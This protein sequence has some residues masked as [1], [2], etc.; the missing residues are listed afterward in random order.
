MLERFLGQTWVMVVAFIAGPAI[1]YLMHRRRTRLAEE[2]SRP[3]GTAAG[4]PAAL[5]KAAPSAAAVPAPDKAGVRK[6][7]WPGFRG[8]KWGQPPVEGMTLVHEEGETRF[9]VR[10]SDELRIG[11]VQIGSATYSF[12]IGRLEAVV[13]DLPLAGFELLTR[14]LTS[15]WGTPKSA[16]DRGKHVW[17]DPGTGPDDSQAVLEKRTESRTARLVLSSRAALAERSQGR[18]G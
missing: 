17:S 14:H 6:Q 1:L 7:L 3:G 16:A 18:T 10:P 5:A 11:N 15:E 9:L 12:R 8:L 4:R 2:A 13:I